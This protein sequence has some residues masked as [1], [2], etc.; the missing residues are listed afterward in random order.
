GFEDGHNSRFSRMI[1]LECMSCHNAMPLG[2]VAGSENK[3]DVVPNGIDCERCHGPGEAHVRKI[4]SGRL[5]DTSQ[6]IDH[7]IVN[8]AKLDVELQFQ[9]CQRCHLQG[10]AVLKKG[11]SFLDFKPGMEL[12]EIMDI[13]M[14]R[15]ENSKDAFIMASHVDRFKMSE[16]FK[17]GMGKFNCTSCHDPHVS[18]RET[19]IEGFNTTCKKCHEGKGHPRFSCTVQ[20]SEFLSANGN[21]VSCHMPSSGSTDIPHVTVHDHFIRKPQAQSSAVEGDFVRLECINEKEPAI[22]SRIRAYLQFYERFEAV[23]HALDSA[24]V[25]IEKAS[26]RESLLFER[27]LFHFLKGEYS[28]IVKWVENQ[29]I[30]NTLRSLDQKDLSNEDAWTAYRIAEAYRSFSDNEN[31]KKFLSRAVELAPFNLDFI[32]KYGTVLS[33][34]GDLDGAIRAFESV[35]KEY[36]LV[37]EA[38]NNLGYL[39]L[40]KGNLEKAGYHLQRAIQLDPDYSQAKI[41]LASLAIAVQNWKEA[42]GLLREILKEDPKNSKVRAALDYVIHQEKFTP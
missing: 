4:G 14:P 3:F 41:N 21:C 36:P 26:T 15:Y 7:S 42:E 11:K 22:T 5:T 9:I 17:A 10:N 13:Y 23:P 30:D 24:E 18:V 33:S 19:R 1:G 16:C 2:F 38:H 32:Q 12:K 31:A 29:G 37:P 8:P 27:V 6:A 39:Q 40:S 20:E 28:Q 35:L 25:L 34:S